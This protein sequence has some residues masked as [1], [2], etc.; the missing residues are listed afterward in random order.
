MVFVYSF[1]RFVD[2]EGEDRSMDPFIGSETSNLEVSAIPASLEIHVHD[3]YTSIFEH[4]HTLV[5]IQ[6]GID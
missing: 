5:V 2:Q 6:T 1:N 3:I 4:L